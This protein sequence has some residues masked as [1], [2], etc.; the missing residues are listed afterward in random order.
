MDARFSTPPRVALHA[1]TADRRGRGVPFA[2][3][4]AQVR[5]PTQTHRARDRGN[6]NLDLDMGREPASRPAP[7]ETIRE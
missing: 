4:F 3:G 5:A 1:G 2:D 7:S 6:K